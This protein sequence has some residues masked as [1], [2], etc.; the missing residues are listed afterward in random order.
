MDAHRPA[1]L[2]GLDDV[3]AADGWARERARAA[4]ARRPAR[5]IV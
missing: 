4:L 5:A 3:L 2:G 1:P